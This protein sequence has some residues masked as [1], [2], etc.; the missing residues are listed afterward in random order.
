MLNDY[1]NAIRHYCELQRKRGRTGQYIRYQ[2]LPDEV[3]DQTL[4]SQR[5]YGVRTE[6]DVVQM[7]AG[8]NGIWEPLPQIEIILPTAMQL[9]QLKRAYGVGDA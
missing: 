6:A 8:V 2:I 9:M 3:Y 4:V 1:H 5:V 7:A